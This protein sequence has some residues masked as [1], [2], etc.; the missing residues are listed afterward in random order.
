MTKVSGIEERNKTLKQVTAS[1]T[2][3]TANRGDFSVFR[4]RIESCAAAPASSGLKH[5]HDE[6]GK[7]NEDGK[8][9]DGGAAERLGGRKKMKKK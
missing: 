7:D 2:G 5:G 8:G 1:K 9:G 4:R 3:L 6:D